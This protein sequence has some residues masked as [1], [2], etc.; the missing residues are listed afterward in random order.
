MI[1]T[2]AETERPMVLERVHTSQGAEILVR[3]H[4]DGGEMVVETMVGCQCDLCIETA[5]VR[6]DLAI[7]AERDIERLKAML[8]DRRG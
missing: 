8:D 2:M 6:V 1:A 4:H 5:L 3:A 7:I